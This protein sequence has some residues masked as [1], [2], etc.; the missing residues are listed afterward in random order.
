MY[1]TTE[2]T[3]GYRQL[4]SLSGHIRFKFT[5]VDRSFAVLRCS[6][7]A[8]EGSAIDD[9]LIVVYEILVGIKR[10]AV[11]GQAALVLDAAGVAAAG[12][13]QHRVRMHRQVKRTVPIKRCLT[14][15][16]TA[17][18]GRSV[19]TAVGIWCTGHVAKF[20]I[21]NCRTQTALDLPFVAAILDRKFIALGVHRHNTCCGITITCRFHG[22]GIH[23]ALHNTNSIVTDVVHNSARPF[24]A[25][26]AAV[27]TIL[28][29][30]IRTLCVSHDTRSPIRSLITDT[31]LIF[32]AD[33]LNAVAFDLDNNTCRLAA[34]GH[35]RLIGTV[36]DL[37]SCSGLAHNARNTCTADR[38]R[39]SNILHRCALDCL[40]QRAIICAIC[41]FQC[42]RLVLT[43]KCS[44]ELYTTSFPFADRRPLLCADINIIVQ[45][46]F[47][48]FERLTV[49]IHHFGK[50]KQLLTAFD[51]VHPI[52]L[53][54]QSR[55][56]ADAAQPQRQYQRQ[57]GCQ[58]FLHVS[59]PICFRFPQ[60]ASF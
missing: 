60:D 11:H 20:V 47:F 25:D 7:A 3:T 13:L 26:A 54:R 41:D 12:D 50:G 21:G 36:D 8:F 59:N 53:C 55:R 31:S 44:L 14:F 58:Q 57:N 30:E 56:P 43:V 28:Y 2:N 15:G 32:A 9:Q 23:T 34:A 6:D 33:N 35:A 24:S 29:N 1:F 5:A 48:A 52:C 37:A 4:P 10:P 22:T 49:V 51:M 16:N 38:T 39:N 18:L 19:L 42:Y 45:H 27:G 40:E 17:A 46:H